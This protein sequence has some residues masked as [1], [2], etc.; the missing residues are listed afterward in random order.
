MF[1]EERELDCEYFS[2][3]AGVLEEHFQRRAV[4]ALSV[5]FLFFKERVGRTHISRRLGLTERQVRGILE[6]LR[7]LGGG[8]LDLLE[9]FLSSLRV[10]RASL[11]GFESTIYSAFSPRLIDC[12]A[13]R[14]IYFRDALVVALEDF[15]KIYLIGVK[16][17]RLDFP[18]APKDLTKVFIENL[19]PKAGANSIVVVWS[20]YEPVVDDVAVVTSLTRM[21]REVCIHIK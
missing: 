20:R 13:N 15:R 16:S 12:L 3:V 5:A 6:K 7:K 21:C 18:M 8:E 10:E 17:N 4:E 14:I 11:N 2:R 9:G 1:R 19:D